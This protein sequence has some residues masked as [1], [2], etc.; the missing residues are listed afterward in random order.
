MKAEEIP[1]IKAVSPNTEDTED[2][3]EGLA[4]KEIEEEGRMIRGKP[5]VYQPTAEEI[6]ANPRAASARFRAAERL[7]VS[8]L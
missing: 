1:A 2:M 6:E 5:K 8:E 7:S 4:E 3:R